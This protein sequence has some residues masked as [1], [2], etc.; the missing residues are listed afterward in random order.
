MIL[1]V[2]QLIKNNA[3]KSLKHH[4]GR[5]IGIL[6][7]LFCVNALFLLLEQFF[8]YLLSLNLT[9]DPALV[10]DLFHG[11]IRLSSSMAIITACFAVVSFVITTP[12]MFGMTKW[13]FHQV[14]GDRPALQTL[15][16]Y[17]YGIRDLFRSIA[18]RFILAVRATL[19]A[20]LFAI[21][22]AAIFWGAW[23]ISFWNSS[24][25]ALLLAVL[26]VLAG[27][28]AIAMAVLW[29]CWIQRYFL[30]D[31]LFVS[32]SGLGLHAMIRKSVRI[33]K[34]HRC[35]TAA[36][37]GSFIPWLLLSVLVAPFLFVLPYLAASMAIHARVLIEQDQRSQNG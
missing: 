18:L 22:P 8:C 1:T 37:Y 30:V 34:N 9:E 31:Y 3:R 5:A 7:F 6:L 4:W 14:G 13:Y 11:Q 25:A 16:T 29:F 24:Y 23:Q 19:W 12:L 15:F 20:L 27:I 33:M 28:V 17:F 26:S 10:V 2:R 35:Q 32:D 21:P 36:L